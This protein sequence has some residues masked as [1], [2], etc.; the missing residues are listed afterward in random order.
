VTAGAG[1]PGGGAPPQQVLGDGEPS[2]AVERQAASSFGY[3]DAK[4]QLVTVDAAGSRRCLTGDDSVIWASW[5]RFEPADVHSWPTWSPDGRRLAA[6]RISREGGEARPIVFEASGMSSTEG[7]ALGGRLPIYLQWSHESEALAILSQDD[8]ELVLERIDPDDPEQT[9]PL[10]RG[11]PLFFSWLDLGRVAAF[12]GEKRGPSMVVLASSGERVDLPGTPGNFC[13]PV[14]VGE[15]LVYVAHHRG[16]VTILVGRPQG[17]GTRELEIVD[18]LVAL[19]GSPDGRCLARAVAPDGDGSCYRDL[20]LLDTRTGETRAVSDADCVAFF[21]ARDKLI[22]AR[23]R[24]QK[25]TIAWMQVSPDTGEEELIAE[26][27]PSRD[28]RF[29]LRFFEQYALSHPIVDRDATR[30]VLSGTLLGR[31]RKRKDDDV[32]RVWV[33]PL[34]GGAPEE[35]DIGPFATFEP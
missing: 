13:A 17:T 25:G 35:V 14:Q 7:A 10:L 34:G 9:R 26:L 15:E 27:Q 6:F 11:S 4:R 23:R 21:W 20:R 16:R 5:G 1:E 29:W 33:V 3:L 2:A 8:S 32:P 22:V 30:L 28:L 31:G 12:V 24:P 19:V 18:G